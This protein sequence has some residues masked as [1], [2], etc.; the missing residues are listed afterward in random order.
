MKPTNTQAIV[1]AGGRG[2]ALMSSSH[3]MHGWE[4]G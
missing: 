2:V 4:E 3:H 1:T